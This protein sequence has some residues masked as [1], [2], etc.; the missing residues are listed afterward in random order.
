MLLT[1]RWVVGPVVVPSKVT[2]S[3]PL[4]WPLTKLVPPLLLRLPKV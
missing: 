4:V 2:E 1:V 3:A